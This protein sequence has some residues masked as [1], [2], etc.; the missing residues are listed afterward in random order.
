MSVPTTSG[1]VVHP[2]TLAINGAM[3]RGEVNGASVR[4]AVRPGA[5]NRDRSRRHDP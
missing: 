1:T 3:T 2:T 5:L 4:P